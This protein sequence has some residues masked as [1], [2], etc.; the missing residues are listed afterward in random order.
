MTTTSSFSDLI[1]KRASNNLHFPQQILTLNVLFSDVN[2]F[3]LGVKQQQQQKQVNCPKTQPW[4]TTLGWI[5]LA[6]KPVHAAVGGMDSEKRLLITPLISPFLLLMT[7]I[8]ILH[9]WQQMGRRGRCVKVCLFKEPHARA[10]F[11][12]Q[13]IAFWRRI[14]AGNT[15][16]TDCSAHILLF[17]VDRGH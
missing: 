15:Q 12:N 13:N 7:I 3:G 4:C 16:A 9:E 10:T 11:R 2:V 6:E 8:T 14:G 5:L 17:V 1:L